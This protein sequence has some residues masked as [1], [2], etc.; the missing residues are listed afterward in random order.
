MNAIEF[1]D[2]DER[3]IAMLR[4]D[5]RLSCRA[6]AGEL[7]VTEAT[8]RTRVKRLE[9][10]NAMRVVAVTD[11]QAAG[12]ELMLAVGIQVDGHSPEEVAGE[13]AAIPEVFSI[14]V[15]VGSCDIETLV[16]ARN[17]AA[18]TE[19][20]YERLARL[21][22][23]LRVLPSLAI[24]VMKN[25]PDTV[26]FYRTAG[27]HDSSDLG[28]ASSRA[29]AVE[30]GASDSTGAMS[31]AE[32]RL[33]EL[34]REIVARLGED[35]RTSNRQ[36]A[37]EVGVTEGTVRSRIRRMLEEKQ[38]RITAVTNIDRYRD[39]AIAYIWVEVE[40]SDQAEKVARQLADMREFGFVGLMMGRLD[41][42][43]IT[44]VRNTEHLS[45]FVHRH[46]SSLPGVRRTESTL[47]V[48]FVKHDYRM[49]RIVG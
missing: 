21:P 6:L 43:G 30:A 15:V 46:I 38:I 49:S 8:V 29:S 27:E 9:T 36:I 48:N 16:V 19:L 35:A 47:G 17:Q 2:T 20:I 3:I 18:L 33:D 11:F 12:Y 4:E 24:D 40:R 14:N 22:G 37:E 42:L 25:Q 10:S 31:P 34:D 7:G 26:P 39:A 23:V 1:D 44:M 45:R 28:G 41:I 32:S 13:L 5:G